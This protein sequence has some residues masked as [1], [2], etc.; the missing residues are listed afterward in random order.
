MRKL[1]NVMVMVLA[2]ALEWGVC[3]NAADT[4]NPRPS[5]PDEI[6]DAWE[7]L[8]QVIHDWNDRFR[9]RFGGRESLENRPVISQLLSRKD[10]LGL[11]ADQVKKLEQ[12]RDNFDRQ[13]IRNNAEVR[14]VEL[15]VAG[16]LDSPTVD[17]AK[18]EAKVRE[19][20]KLRA[21][22]RIARIKAIEQAKALLTPEQRKKFY[23]TAEA[24]ASRAGRAQNPP[25]RE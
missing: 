12:L 7:R 19:A 25:A 14:I 13:N 6:G 8:Q 21:D 11:S 5:I 24:Q 15:D 23:D 4:Q 18:V 10:A 2:L 22:L 9:E 16:L 17:L 1:A 3:A 20:E